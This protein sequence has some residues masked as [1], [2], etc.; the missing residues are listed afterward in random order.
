MLTCAAKS[1]PNQI[2]MIVKQEPKSGCLKIRIAKGRVQI[3]LLNILL[4]VGKFPDQNPAK[5]KI[6]AGFANSEGWILNI[7]KGIHLKEPRV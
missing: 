2:A 4:Q 3:R 6:K 7:P 5:T 1:I